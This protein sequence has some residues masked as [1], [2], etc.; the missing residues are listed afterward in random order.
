MGVGW[1]QNT[2]VLGFPGS[3]RNSQPLCIG[4]AIGHDKFVQK[5]TSLPGLNDGLKGLKATA[6][7]IGS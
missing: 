1:S 7:A 6:R 5:I 4:D 3:I 2:T